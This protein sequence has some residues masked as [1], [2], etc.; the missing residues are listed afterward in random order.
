MSARTTDRPTS[1]NQAGGRSG[2]ALSRA[3]P[4]RYRSRMISSTAVMTIDP[5]PSPCRAGDVAT[6]S[7]YPVRSGRPP[8]C[9]SRSTMAA[10]VEISPSTSS[11]RWTP[12]RACSQSASVKRSSTSSQNACLM[13]SRM[14]SIS[15]TVRSAVDSCRSRRSDM[16]AT[17]Q[18]RISVARTRCRR[19]PPGHP[20]D[21]AGASSRARCGSDRPP[22]GTRRR[23]R[24]RDRASPGGRHA[25]PAGGGS[26]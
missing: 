18:H 26:P 9:S 11:T 22:D 16:E 20:P 13:S 17:V 1:T 14:I 25:R 21:P 2:G 7:T 24:R 6:A 10:W 15:A 3:H 5:K 8:T 19:D 23:P 4:A 12:P